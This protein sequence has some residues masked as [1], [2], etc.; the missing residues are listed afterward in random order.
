MSK[1]EKIIGSVIII[2]LVI[3]FITVVVLS[4]I[5]SNEINK[6]VEEN[7]EVVTPNIEEPE[8]KETYRLCQKKGE[9]VEDIYEETNI[10]YIEVDDERVIS[11]HITS[12]LKFLTE[13][14]YQ[15]AKENKTYGDTAIYDD[16]A[17]TIEYKLGEENDYTKDD[18]GVEINVKYHEFIES[19]EQNGYVCDK[20]NE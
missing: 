2:V 4:F 10:D 12:K 16:N 13:E 20:V 17:L 18:N 14:N 1:K 7:P 15:Q 3:I 19:F 11:D 5:K 9:T 8:D 6:P